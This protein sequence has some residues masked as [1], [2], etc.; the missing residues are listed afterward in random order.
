[1]G[2]GYHRRNWTSL[3]EEIPLINIGQGEVIDFIQKHITYRFGN[4]ETIT[5]DQGSIFIGRK[6]QE[7]ASEI[8]FKLVTSTPY[9]PQANGQV[10]ASNEIIIGLIKKHVSKKP[11]NW[12]KH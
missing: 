7:F 8:G 1:M 3:V 4:P 11:K 10:K 5:I 2:A 12:K 6:M 9:Y